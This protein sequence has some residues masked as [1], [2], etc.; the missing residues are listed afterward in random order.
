MNTTPLSTYTLANT[1]NYRWYFTKNYP[2]LYSLSTP[3]GFHLALLGIGANVGG[4]SAILKRFQRLLKKLYTLGTPLA[5]SPILKNP[6][7]GSVSFS[8]DY[9]NAVIL[10]KTRLNLS[11][12]RARMFY[13]ER[14]FGRKRKRI[15]K[16][17]AR[18]MD[19]DILDYRLNAKYAKIANKFP[20]KPI[21]LGQLLTTIST[22]VANTCQTCRSFSSK[23]IQRLRSPKLPL[24][25]VFSQNSRYK[26]EIKSPHSQWESRD[27]V[28]LPLLFLKN[29]FR[30]CL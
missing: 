23:P 20:K 28:C 11:D 10:L 6:A 16:N 29:Y 12:F 8:P 27:S 22:Q 15:Q 2:H 24:E 26:W 18:S 13:I 19:L 5:N 9:F 7:F 1:P 14:I 4:E 17:E 25:G 30:G 3:R 21:R